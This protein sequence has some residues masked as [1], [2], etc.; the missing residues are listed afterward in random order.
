V[1]ALLFVPSGGGPYAGLI[2]QHG[3]P[4]G[5]HDVAFEAEELARLGA[6]VIAI[7]AP[8][9]RRSGEPIAF[10]R[11]DREEQIQLIVDLRRAVDLLRA[12][13]DVDDDRIAYL[14]ISYGAAI[15]Q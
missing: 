15:G 4:G 3:L 13:A 7:D 10:T 11:R 1:P 5:K 14:G 6:V 9:A 8:F 2:V 12:R